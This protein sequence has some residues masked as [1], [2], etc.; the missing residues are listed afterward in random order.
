MTGFSLQELYLFPAISI[1]DKFSHTSGMGRKKGT[2]LKYVRTLY[3]SQRLSA[4]K[5]KLELNLLR[6]YQSLIDLGGGIFNSSQL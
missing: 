1:I 3:S 4:G 2:I 5:T 6:Y